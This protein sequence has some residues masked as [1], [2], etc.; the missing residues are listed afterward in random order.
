MIVGGVGP[1]RVLLIVLLM[2]DTPLIL[3]L[4]A[5]FRLSIR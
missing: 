2:I 1:A 5:P 4:L 3:L